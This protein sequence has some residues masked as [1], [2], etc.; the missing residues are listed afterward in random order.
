MGVFER[1][2]IRNLWKENR[3]LILKYAIKDF[4]VEGLYS[5]M[6]FRSETLKIRLY[7]IKEGVKSLETTH[8]HKDTSLS[9]HN[10]PFDFQC[11]TLTGYMENLIYY[12]DDGTNSI[13]YSQ[14]EQFEENKN[15]KWFKYTYSGALMDKEKK[16]RLKDEENVEIIGPKVQKVPKGESYHFESIELHRIR[17]PSNETTIMLFWEHE[18]IEN[19]VSKI[20]S[21]VALPEATDYSS[22][23][24][25]MSVDEVEDLISFILNS[26]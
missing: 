16:M 23:Y 11:Q 20:Y 3:E 19:F 24:Q 9:V 26:I 13:D 8:L 2:F 22:F 21:S 10:H 17:V 4:H 5:L 15:T 12:I 25:P 6:L 18:K 7:V 14:I 1:E